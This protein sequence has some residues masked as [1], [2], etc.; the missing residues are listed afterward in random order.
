MAVRI[1]RIPVD[2][3][4]L[5][6]IGYDKKAKVLYAEF[7]NTGKIFAY[8]E[9]PEE[10]FEE[11]KNAD[12]VGRYMRANIIDIYPDYKVKRGSEFRW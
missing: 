11:L 2:S 8:E 10:V 7:L 3:S 9:V 4:M 1:I 12:S 5:S 6:A